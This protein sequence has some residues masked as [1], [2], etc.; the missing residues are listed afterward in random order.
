MATGRHP[1]SSQLDA[2]R[3]AYNMPFRRSARQQGD[4]HAA[5][6]PM[7][8]EAHVRPASGTGLAAARA[9]AASALEHAN[10]VLGLDVRAPKRFAHAASRSAAHRRQMATMVTRRKGHPPGRQSRPQRSK[11]AS[12]R[13]VVRTTRPAGGRMASSTLGMLLQPVA[14]EEAAAFMATTRT[15]WRP[16]SL[17]KRPTR[18]RRRVRRSRPAHGLQHESSFIDLRDAKPAGASGRPPK[19]PTFADSTS[20]SEWTSASTSD[21]DT[22]WRVDSDDAPSPPPPPSMPPRSPRSRDHSTA[23]QHHVHTRAWEAGHPVHPHG[24][25][26]S[27][28]PLGSKP[29]SRKRSRPRSAHPAPTTQE[30]VATRTQPVQEARASRRRPASAKP[31]ASPSTRAGEASGERGRHG[32]SSRAVPQQGRTGARR[33]ARQRPSSAVARRRSPVANVPVTSQRRASAIS[34]T[35][36][37]RSRQHST[38][39]ATT[40]GRGVDNEPPPRRRRQRPSSAAVRRPNDAPGASPATPSVVLRRRR[41]SAHHTGLPIHPGAGHNSEQ[42]AGGQAWP[43]KSATAPRPKPVPHAP[44]R[45]EVDLGPSA[46]LVAAPLKHPMPN[47]PHTF[48][49]RAAP[50][51]YQG[52]ALRTPNRVGQEPSYP[53]RVA[54]SGNAGSSMTRHRQRPHSAVVRR[55]HANAVVPTQSPPQRAPRDARSRASGSRSRPQSAMVRGRSRRGRPGVHKEQ[56]R[57][58]SRPHRANPVGKATEAGERRASRSRS[59]RTRK[60][61]SSAFPRGDTPDARYR[62]ENAAR[63]PSS[64]VQARKPPRV[65]ML[66]RPMPTRGVV[67]G[68]VELDDGFVVED[69][70]VNEEW[71]QQHGSGDDGGSLAA[72]GPAKTERRGRS[73]SPLGCGRP[74]ASGAP[75]DGGNAGNVLSPA[76]VRPQSAPAIRRSPLEETTVARVTHGSRPFSAGGSHQQDSRVAAAAASTVT[77]AL[78]HSDQ[79]VRCVRIL[80]RCVHV[81]C[82]YC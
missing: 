2:A 48:M 15:A 45:P 31:I 25:R 29:L 43:A 27:S 78:Y 79:A 63:R 54:A 61:P 14:A 39:V 6:R 46:R 71:D 70:D 5:A 47:A 22:G 18:R 44:E 19:R 77:E 26:G 76:R 10:S 42:G 8:T 40:V 9:H 36:R 75:I 51:S 7:H 53:Q 58:R 57:S 20:G 30:R 37:P 50:P 55:P 21:G 73:A 64:A 68:G 33:R 49:V 66:S 82:F 34:S 59:P 28:A 60:R 72:V 81:C 52:A 74:S 24:E 23:D 41:R 1:T 80:Q 62:S 67:Y 69:D 12:T 13:T 16:R 65:N 11:P 3:A 35:A 38:A 56:P 4:Q 17:G 32:S